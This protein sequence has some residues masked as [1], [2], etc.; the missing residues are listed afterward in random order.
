MCLTDEGVPQLLVM[1]HVFV[2]YQRAF[3][4]CAVY[5]SFEDVFGRFQ[6]A[7]SS[8]F[9]KVFLVPLPHDFLNLFKGVSVDDRLMRVLNDNPFFLR[10]F[11]LPAVFIEGLPFCSLNHVPDVYLAGQNN[12]DCLYMPYCTIILFRLAYAGIVEIGRRGRDAGI[13][14]LLCYPCNAHTLGAPLKYLPHDGSSRFIRL[15][16]MRIIYTLA[17][18][19]WSPCADKVSVRLLCS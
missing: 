19:V 9:F 13:V 1:A 8:E 18:S 17:V 11:V 6:I 10:L 14:E 4:V 15:Q 5:Q 2:P 3:A 7:E 12:L 16:L